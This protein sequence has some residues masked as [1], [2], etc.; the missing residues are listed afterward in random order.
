MIINGKK[1]QLKTKKKIQRFTK[2]Y[3]L[4]IQAMDSIVFNNFVSWN[5]LLIESNISNKNAKKG[6][7][8]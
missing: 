3:N 1:S 6:E 5:Q 8:D 7:L 4:A 2:I